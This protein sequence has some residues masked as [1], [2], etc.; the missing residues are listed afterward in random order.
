[1]CDCRGQNIFRK[2]FRHPTRRE[3]VFDYFFFGLHFR[4]N[5]P[6]PGVRPTTSLTEN[7]DVGLHLKMP[8]DFAAHDPFVEEELTYVSSDTEPTG[9]PSLGKDMEFCRMTLSRSKDAKGNSMSSQRI[10]IS[11]YGPIPCSGC[12]ALRKDSRASRKIGTND[13]FFLGRRERLTKTALFPLEQSMFWV[14]AVPIRRPTWK[15]S[16]LKPL[17]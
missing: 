5:L 11:P 4:S 17:S 2:I 6:L 3:L 1:M 15:H 14:I 12:L 10:P 16:G 13:V 7:S 8:P 9:E